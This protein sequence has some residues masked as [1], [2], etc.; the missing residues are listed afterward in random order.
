M[1]RFHQLWGCVLIAFGLGILFGA[2]L[3]G[4]FLCTC[5]G[6]GLGC[7]GLMLLRKSGRA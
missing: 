1:C 3:E 4:G 7:S 2:W 5:F 6:L